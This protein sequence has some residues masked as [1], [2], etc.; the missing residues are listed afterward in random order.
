[1][2]TFVQQFSIKIRQ[3]IQPI[4]ASTQ[5]V[6]FY[7]ILQFL[8]IHCS[9]WKCMCECARE[10]V[11]VRERECVCVS[12]C[13]RVCVR[14]CVRV[15]VCACVRLC[16]CACA[17]YCDIAILQ[18]TVINPYRYAI[19]FFVITQFST[20]PS[21]KQTNLSAYIIPLFI[22]SMIHTLYSNIMIPLRNHA[23]S[24]NHKLTLYNA[25]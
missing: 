11:C 15:C 5:T 3:I 16:V 9:Q 10:C 23:L 21:R 18:H 13:M 20:M 12:V 8:D 17:R 22:W 24:V 14:A 2:F 7:N 6:S 4:P 25:Y 1:M 19:R